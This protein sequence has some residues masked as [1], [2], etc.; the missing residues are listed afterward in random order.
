M[1]YIYKITNQINGKIYIGKTSHLSLEERFQEHIKDSQKQRSEKRPLYDAFNK[2][3]VNNFTIDLIEEVENDVIASQKEEYW[4]KKLNSYIGFS[5]SNGYNATLGGDGK[6]IYDY[7]ILSQEYESLGTIRAVCLKYNCDEQT[8]RQACKENNVLIKIAPNQKEI[9][10]TDKHNNKI[11]FSSIT[12]AAKSIL[13]KD[14]ETARKNISRALNK[15]STH[16]AY[17]YT[18]HYIN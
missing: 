6:R 17:G 15:S 4:I 5:D 9:I 18:W 8:V 10:R 2:Y 12:E 16:I 14:L 1:P 3:G 13:N 11:K 7:Q